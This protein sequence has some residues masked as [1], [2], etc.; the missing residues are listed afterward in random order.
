M[1]NALFSVNAARVALDGG[2]GGS[3]VACSQT[4]DCSELSLVELDRRIAL[5]RPLGVAV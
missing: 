2:V 5:F 3:P 4:A 1:P